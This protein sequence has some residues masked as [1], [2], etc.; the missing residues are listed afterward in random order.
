MFRESLKA[1]KAIQTGKS[2][3][4]GSCTGERVYQIACDG[5]RTV[6]RTQDI[7][8]VGWSVSTKRL[9]DAAGNQGG[10]AGTLLVLELDDLGF[11]DSMEN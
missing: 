1:V 2:N 10:T 11:F 8:R 6:I 5:A 3:G 4:L 9:A 7:D